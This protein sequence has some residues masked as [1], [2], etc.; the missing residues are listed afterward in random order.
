MVVNW[1]TIVHPVP[2]SCPL[3]LR[4][5]TPQRETIHN[6]KNTRRIL[7]DEE[8]RMLRSFFSFSRTVAGKKSEEW[9][10]LQ[11]S[12]E[13]ARIVSTE[14]ERENFLCRSHS[15]FSLVASSRA[16]TARG[17][18]TAVTSQWKGIRYSICC[19][20]SHDLQ[21]SGLLSAVSL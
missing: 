18:T 21:L 3:M 2:V 20:V 12:Y 1:P 16:L 8:I 9:R 7:I 4:M 10:E 11:R 5:E 15:Y 13:E 14:R 19:R 6:N 17:R